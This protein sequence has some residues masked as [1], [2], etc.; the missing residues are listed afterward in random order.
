MGQCL[1]PRPG[2]IPSK[3]KFIADAMLGRLARWLRLLGF[4]TLYERDIR[5]GDLLKLAIREDRIV[6]TR[7]RHFL[8]IKN[9]KNLLMIHSDYPLDQVREVLTAF[10]I[11]AFKSGRCAQ[12]NGILDTVNEKSKIRNLVPDHIFFS[13]AKFQI[14]SSCGKIFWEGTHLRRFRETIGPLVEESGRRTDK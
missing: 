1:L 12:C 2:L 3:M 5:D 13:H 10:G 8:N 4:D 9:L 11:R 7:D 14:C 6:L